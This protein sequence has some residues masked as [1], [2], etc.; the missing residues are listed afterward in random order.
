M[1]FASRVL[2]GLMLALSALSGRAEPIPI[3]NIGI[4]ALRSLPEE[5]ARWKPLEDYLRW[6]L[7]NVGVRVQGYDLDG[8]ESAIK[9]RRVDIVITSPAAYLVSAH[10]AGLSAPLV[11]E[12]EAAGGQPL[13]GSGGAILVRSNRADL[14]SLHDLRGKRIAAWASN[15]L[16]GYQAEAYELAAVGIELPQDA[17]LVITGPPL[18]SVLPPLL[19][20]EVDAVF[21]RC[22]LLEDWI[23][24]G[25]VAPGALRVLHARHLPDFPYA[26]STP[27]YPG[28][29]V[30]AM[31]QLDE[32]LAKQ[33]AAALLQMP[34]GGSVAQGLGIYGFTLPYDYEPV[35]E[36]TRALRLPPYDHEPPV[37]WHQIWRT[38][39]PAIIALAVAVGTIIA[40]ALL[41]ALY[42]ARLAAARQQA[43]QHAEGLEQ[44]RTLL[45]TLLRTMPDMVWLKDNDG[46]FRFCN[47]A[48]ETL[49][50]TTEENI[51]GRTDYD[52]FDQELADFFREHDRVAAGA[53]KPTTN[54]EWLTSFDGRHRGLYLT[55]K[56]PVHGSDGHLIG[57]LGVA[58]DITPLRET[59]KAL[60]ERIKEQNCLHAVFR[61][62][63]DRHASLADL[64]QG[65]AEVLPSGW[66][67][68]ALAVA[69]V[70]FDR[71]R[72]AKAGCRETSWTQTASIVIDGEERGRVSVGYLEPCPDH[73]EG[74][75]LQEERVLLDAVAARVAGTIKRRLVEDAARQREQVFRAI[76]SQASEAIVLLDAET[77]E[78]IEFNE[79]ACTGLGYGREEFARLSAPAIQ[80]ELDEPT[81]LALTQEIIRAGTGQFESIHRHKDGAMQN[82]Y[83]S[84]SALRIEDRDCLSIIWQDITERKQTEL[85]LA[86]H[87]QHLEQLVEERTD[88]LA[89]AKEQAEAASR[90]KSLFLANM[91]HEIRTPLNAILG[92]AY[93]LQRDL[94]DSDKRQKLDKIANSARHLLGIID[95][96]LDLSKI[97]AD[98]LTPEEIPISVAAIIEHV[99]DM[100]AERVAGKHL[101]WVEDIAPQLATFQLL[102]DPL[103]LGQILINYLSN[104]VKFTDQGSITVRAEVES[105]TDG[106]VA[107]RFEVLDTGIGMSPE[108]QALVF[109]A[110]EQA[111]SST[112]RQYGGTGLGL[113]IARRLA[114][115]M[116]G[117]AGVESEPGRGSRFW[118]TVCLKRSGRVPR[119]ESPS[120]GGHFRSGARVLLVE[121]NDINQE[122]A[123]ELLESVGLVV[124]VAE[125][126]AEAV[127]RVR[128]ESY[129]L[130]FMDLQMPV[131]GGIEATRKIREMPQGRGTPILAM[132][133]NAF[134]EDRRECLNAGMNDHVAKPVEVRE[135]YAALARWIT[136]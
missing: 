2:L 83:V 52:F 26:L 125:N 97:E 88:E 132:T 107:L 39:R 6:N 130:I 56:M 9:G 105:E 58:R 92:L 38:Y 70:E 111:Q 20:G 11:S 91:S 7:G 122:V 53:V 103:R 79:A 29:P 55:T 94:G 127:D 72:Y 123:R 31:P 3:L 30:A 34:S 89:A 21:A 77:L 101:R 13:P 104:A 49:F 14:Q 41:L 118:F 8:M 117:E 113:S 10:R 82:V 120:P 28:R 131:M 106:H 24:E 98:R 87:R 119:N 15:D 86:R 110:F 19:K 135:L 102:G 16:G 12:V 64:F 112:T 35:R 47:P 51:V 27:L 5:T 93:L 75:F 66:S 63:E 32:D 60:G 48:F 134:P 133:A 59:E 44:E 37:T 22:G 114:R 115:L 45:R 57:V 109:D 124:D 54:E 126:G 100:M 25:K 74:P 69:C 71:V 121:D 46:V 99:R 73:G 85:E 1:R 4:L 43:D 61:V 67:H 33:V 90:A 129:D 68:D 116:G 17:R 128:A 42:A 36:V 78:F 76:V 65:V 40:L 84:F 80:A 18:D 95:D 136:E 108:H 23:D 50:G 81:M 62:T 96:I